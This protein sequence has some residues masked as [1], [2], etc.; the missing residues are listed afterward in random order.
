MEHAV[1]PEM[2]V[3]SGDAQMPEIIARRD[4]TV[5]SIRV[6]P[7]IPTQPAMAVCAPIVQLC[8]IWIWYRLDVVLDHRV[9]IAPRSIV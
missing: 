8:P 5:A 2:T 6:L 1:Q 9:V 7:A 3:L 4:L